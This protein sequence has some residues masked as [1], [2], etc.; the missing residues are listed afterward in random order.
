[1]PRT[2]EQLQQ[3]AADAER[4]LDG[5]DPSEVQAEDTTDLRQVGLALAEVAQAEDRLAH[6]VWAARANGRSW[7]QIALVLGVTKQAAAERFGD[8]AAAD[9]IH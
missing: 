4:W 8:R 9:D 5:L 3:A 6:A 7:A 1:M 2:R